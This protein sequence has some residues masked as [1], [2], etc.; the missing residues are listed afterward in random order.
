[1]GLQRFDPEQ[2]CPKC[3][4]QNMRVE[5]HES[6]IVHVGDEEFPCAT[7]SRKGILTGNIGEH[8]CLRCLRC[9]YGRP[10]STVDSA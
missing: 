9:N 1:M 2:G 10:T 7:W 6:L 8:L 4:G 3:G 5:F